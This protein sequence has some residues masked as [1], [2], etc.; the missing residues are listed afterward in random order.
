MEG[1]KDILLQPR[2]DRRLLPNV[3]DKEGVRTNSDRRGAVDDN[4]HDRVKKSIDENGTGIRYLVDYPVKVRVGRKLGSVTCTAMDI[5][6]SGMAL[7]LKPELAQKIEVGSKLRLQFEILPGTMPEGYESKVKI[8]AQC[9]RLFTNAEGEPCC[10]VEFDEGLAQYVS[11]TRNRYAFPAVCFFMFFVIFMIVMMRTESVLYFKFNKWLYLYSIVAAV[12]LLT[13]YLFAAFYK[14]VPIDPK[15]TPGVTIIIPCF[16]EETWIR[17]TIISCLNQDY[18][19]DKLEVIV[20][21]DHSTD[22]SVEKIKETIDE[23][24]EKEA[25]YDVRDRLS[26]FVQPKNAGKREAMAVGT[27][28][29]KHDLVVFVDSDSFLNPFAI[30]NIVQPFKDKDMGG[31][32]GRTDVANTYTNSLTKLQAVRYYISFRIMKAAEAYFDAVTCLSGPLSCYRKDLVMENMDAWLNQTFLGQ[33]A[34]FGDD[35]SMTN[36]ILRKHRTSYQDTAICATIVPNDYEVFLRQQMRWKRSWLRESINAGRFMWKK[37]PFMALF[38]YMGVLVPIVAPAI[39]LY[40]LVYV[41]IAHRVFPYTFILGMILMSLM[42]SLT[43]KILRKSTTWLY[44]L[45]F[46][47]YYEAVLLWQMPIAWVTF[48][49]ANW[50]TRMT[51]ADVDELNK[52]KG[53]QKAKEEKKHSGDENADR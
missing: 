35:R 21:D 48:W 34:T 43:Q 23:L 46:C 33:K 26:Y 5:S 45:W 12:F 42:M 40:N 31:V 44:G 51:Q 27:K 49:K 13:R 30:Y 6:S 19:L 29:A 20:I 22:K 50:G 8:D 3:P 15:F 16:N 2:P 52:K 4:I 39:V 41:P 28:L 38:F 9:V 1:K 32:S 47:L 25:R 53:K 18:P 10:G 17:R 14:P 36:F 7:R 11:R 37:E 24:S